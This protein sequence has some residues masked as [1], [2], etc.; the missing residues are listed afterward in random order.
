MERQVMP[1]KII[2]KQEARH[3]SDIFTHTTQRGSHLN[4]QF[5]ATEKK[6]CI[7]SKFRM[8]LHI[9]SYAGLLASPL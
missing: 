7:C 9:I 5:Q 6:S 3:F 4:Y 1:D 2:S 8:T